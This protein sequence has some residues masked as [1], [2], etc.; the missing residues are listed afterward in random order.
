MD[1]NQRQKY[2]ETTLYRS[3]LS[4]LPL[5]GATTDPSVAMNYNQSRANLDPQPLSMNGTRGEQNELSRS[6]YGAAISLTANGDEGTATTLAVN[7]PA[8]HLFWAL[9][10][11]R[12]GKRLSS[13]GARLLRAAG[14]LHS[15]GVTFGPTPATSFALIHRRWRTGRS[16]TERSGR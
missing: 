7:G 4:I 8:K 6:V 5:T 3:L 16:R 11:L 12:S 2:T 15:G 10:G 14:K 9:R 13:G 1:P